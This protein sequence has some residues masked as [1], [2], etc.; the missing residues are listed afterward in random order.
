MLET[1]DFRQ[2][3]ADLLMS[4]VDDHAAHY[5]PNP[6]PDIGRFTNIYPYPS[7]G[8]GMMA[9]D[10]DMIGYVDEIPENDLNDLAYEILKPRENYPFGGMKMMKNIYNSHLLRL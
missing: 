10:Q 3:L 8:S 1:D 6:N 9:L 5:N 7:T 2:F 4:L